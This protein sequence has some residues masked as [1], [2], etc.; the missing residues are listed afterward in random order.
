MEELNMTNNNTSTGIGNLVAALA[1][2]QGEMK[3]ARRDSENPFFKHKYA[4]LASVCEASFP[5]LSKNG[6]AIFQTLSNRNGS[7]IIHTTLAHS[8]GEWVRGE[9]AVTP[10]KNDPQGLGSAITYGR[11]YSHMAI[12]GLPAEDDDG[13]SAMGRQEKKPEIKTPQ[14]KKETLTKDQP[15]AGQPEEKSDER[16]ISDPQRKRFYAIAKGS[17]KTDEQIKAYLAIA[18][19][20]EHTADIPVIMYDELC[21][22]AGEKSERSAGEGDE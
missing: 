13:E 5:F 11:R 14:A 6:L 2:A 4:D 18:L 17:G 16:K 22:W 3:G 1:K 19:N 12:I 8:S 20:I 21:E 10:V 15:E 7:V 9:L